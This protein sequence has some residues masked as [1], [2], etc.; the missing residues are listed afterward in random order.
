MK[1][2]FTQLALILALSSATLGSVSLAASA[3]TRQNKPAQ[4]QA[5]NA[6]LKMK[7]E[8]EY[9]D[10]DPL[11]G[12]KSVG[13]STVTPARGT[14]PFADA[15]KTAKFAVVTSPRGQDIVDLS[16]AADQMGKMGMGGPGMS[17]QGGNQ[18]GN[19]GGKS[20]PRGNQ[21]GQNGQGGPQMGGPRGNQSGQD[22]QGGPQMGGPRGGNQTISFFDGNP[23]SGGKLIK[24]FEMTPKANVKAADT[25]ATDT[26]AA[27]Q[28]A[29]QAQKLEVDKVAKTAKFA[30]LQRDGHRHIVDLS[31]QPW[32]E[33]PQHR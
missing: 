18:G 4:M 5:Q 11:K 25:K 23:L 26:K 10:A 8:V 29:D 20:G 13:K 14:S 27:N 3:P 28:A 1:K 22:G 19:Q 31:T 16:Q 30:L 17:D 32:N 33:M 2:T 24:S 12:G 15:P 6:P 21:G 9:F 7:L